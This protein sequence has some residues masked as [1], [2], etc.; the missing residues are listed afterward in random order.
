RRHTD[1]DAVLA[2]RPDAVL[3][4]AATEAHPELV[5]RLVEAGVPTYVDKPLAYELRESRRVADL[6]EQRGV[7]L[8]VGFNRRHAPGYA[9]C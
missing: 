9:Q 8:M 3:V 5:T 2:A 6:A 7:P 4:H 1:L